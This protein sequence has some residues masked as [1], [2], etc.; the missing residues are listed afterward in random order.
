MTPLFVDIDADRSTQNSWRPENICEIAAHDGRASFY[1][2]PEAFLDLVLSHDA[3]S[4]TWQFFRK[5]L[6]THLY[7]HRDSC[8]PMHILSGLVTVICETVRL[9][10]TNKHTRG[11]H[12]HSSVTVWLAVVILVVKS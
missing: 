12:H 10:R 11:L 4:L 2:H 1:K 7:I 3:G 8:H 9:W 6:N 5:P